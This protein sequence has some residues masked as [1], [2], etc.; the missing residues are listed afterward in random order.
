V[1]LRKVNALLEHEAIVQVISPKLC[2]ELEDLFAVGRIMAAKRPYADGDL[3][4][5]FVAIAATDD[6]D[7]NRKVAAEAEKLGVL[8]NVVDTPNQ[9]NFIVPAHLRRGD[10][11]IAVSTGGASPA[12]ARRIRE[13]LE[14]NFGEEY[15][16]LLAL[17]GQVRSDLRQNGAAAAGGDWQKALDIDALLALI[18]EGKSDEARRRMMDSL[19]RHDSNGRE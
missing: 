14:G 15:E 5:A 12:L 18:R 10:L 13:K 2:P 4:G 19:D 16:T 11:S 9:S 8:V 7:T 17:A 3:A 6:F 1:A